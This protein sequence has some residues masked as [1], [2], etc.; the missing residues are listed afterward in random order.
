MNWRESDDDVDGDVDDKIV[1]VNDE[2][3]KLEVK[4][5]YGYDNDS[6]AD[7]YVKDEF[8]VGIT[9]SVGLDIDR[10]DDSNINRDIGSVLDRGVDVEFGVYMKIDAI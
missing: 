7:I 9:D 5:A 6:S 10:N 3:R 1:S 2:E 4:N 8:D